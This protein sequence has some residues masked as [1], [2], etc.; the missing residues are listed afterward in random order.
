MLVQ[1]RMKY[2]HTLRI[3]LILLVAV[4]GALVLLAKLY[5][6]QIQGH[7]TFTTRADKQ[8]EQRTTPLFDRGTIFFTSKDNERRSAATVYE[9]VGLAIDPRMIKDPEEVF[10]LLK[11]HVALDR[12]EFLEKAQ[13]KDDPYEEL[14]KRLETTTG[15]AIRALKIPGVIIYRDTWRLYPANKVAAHAIGL[16][17]YKGD[18]FRGRYGL[19]SYYDELLSKQQGGRLRNF[20]AEVFS[21]GT[22]SSVE[23]A[24]DVVTSLEPSVQNFIETTLA[25]TKDRWKPDEIGAIVMDPY[26]GSVIAMSALPNFNPNDVS[27]EKDARVFSNPLVENAYEMGS[28]IKPLT[29]AI[30]L[31]TGA[32]TTQTTYND[33]GT[34]TVNQKKISNYDGKARGVVPMQ[35]VLSQSLNVGIAFIVQKMGY[36]HIPDYYRKFGFGELTEIDQPNETKGITKNLGSTRD[37]EHITMGYGQGISMSPIATVRALATLANGGNLVRPHIAQAI[38]HDDGSVDLIRNVEPVQVL[39][40]ETTETVTKMLVEVVDKALRQGE[41]KMPRYSIAA[42]TGTAQIADPVQGGYYTDRYLHS[43][44]GYFPAYNPKFIVFLY[45][46]HPKNAAYASETLTYPFI[47]IAK[48]LINYYDIPPDR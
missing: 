11:M 5:I 26:T 2:N 17:G 16:L 44:F 36:Q 4:L 1:L 37:V 38:E 8:Y 27:Q 34:I 9:G 10:E 18:E 15:D 30:A 46:V 12:D 41:V 31:D 33:T 14:V 48:F 32:I 45:Q 28:I 47:D 35:E 23:S 3:H 21:G 40:K 29:M 13:K 24:G 22:R 25:S 43:F 20:F 39:K 7:E 19:E 42:K 6:V